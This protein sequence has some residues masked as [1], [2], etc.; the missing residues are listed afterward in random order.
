M[1]L[2]KITSLDDNLDY[3]SCFF[4]FTPSVFSLINT[5]KILFF[6]AGLLIVEAVFA[7]SG[8]A[9]MFSRI[10]RVSRVRL[11]WILHL[12]GITFLAIGFVI[13]LVNKE[14]HNPP[15][16]HFTTTHGLLGLV[17]IILT[18]LV[19]AFGIFANNTN[20]LYPH[21]RPVTIKIL[22]A[23][24]GICITVLL[25][26]TFVNGT[27]KG[28]MENAGGDTARG[29]ILAAIFIGGF[30]VLI[31]PIIGAAT[32]CRVLFKGTKKQ[33]QEKKMSMETSQKSLD[34]VDGPTNDAQAT[35]TVTEITEKSEV[36]MSS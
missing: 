30:L 11:H 26:V 5:Y 17:T 6:Q 24:A 4:V 29:L 7:I 33:E 13:I 14:L 10:T 27:F 12:V 16:Y 19:A 15:K 21:I 36:V 34:Q 32:R 1:C 2:K 20:W 8:E 9:I 23:F 3:K 25:L 22:H 18:V 28:W 35:M 31:R